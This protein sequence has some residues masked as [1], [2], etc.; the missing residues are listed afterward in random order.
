MQ[1]APSM[2]QTGGNSMNTCG[3]ALL[4][5][6]MT[7]PKSC[8][9]AYTCRHEK[10]HKRDRKST[11]LNSSHVAISYA[12]FCLKKRFSNKQQI[13]KQI[14]KQ[15]LLAVEQILMKERCG[16]YH[17]QRGQIRLQTPLRPTY[18]RSQKN[19]CTEH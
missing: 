9:A 19:D 2:F 7:Q 6:S 17:E 3:P 16:G 13:N 8:L 12:V 5:S 18:P 14:N 15:T 10:T 11:R 4:P 1:G